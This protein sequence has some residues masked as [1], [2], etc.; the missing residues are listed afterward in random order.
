M[1]CE[2]KKKRQVRKERR[3]QV[4]EGIEKENI[5]LASLALTLRPLR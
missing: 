4:E 5:N 3:N 1:D 2:I